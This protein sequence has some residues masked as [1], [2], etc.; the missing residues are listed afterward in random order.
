MASVAAFVYFHGFVERASAAGWLENRGLRLGDGLF[1]TIRV[2]SGRPLFVAEHLR[3]L[4]Q[5]LALLEL[6]APAELGPGAL[7]HLLNELVARNGYSA[8]AK[9]RLTVWRRGGEGSYR[10]ASRRADFLLEG[11]ELLLGAYTLGRDQRLVLC[12]DVVVQPWALAGVKTLSALPYVHA[13]QVAQRAGADDALLLS[14]DGQVAEAG[15]ANIFA[16]SGG[17][18]LT[19][20]LR[21]GCLDGVLRRVLLAHAPSR[22]LPLAEGPLT[23]EDLRAAEALFTTNVVSGILP[24]R[25][26]DLPGESGK[27]YDPQH[28]LIEAAHRALLHRVKG[29]LQRELFT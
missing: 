14:S 21:T 19:P 28:P 2:L 8:G 24:V 4:H 17:R 12:R 16:V 6:D 1:E 26:L 18:I 9:L 7:P 29:D 13:A 11:A 15:R 23:L 27:S 3:R 10:P 22:Q 25:Y 5:G 20:P